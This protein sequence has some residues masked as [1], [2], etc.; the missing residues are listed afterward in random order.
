MLQLSLR[1]EAMK[2]EIMNQ[3]RNELLKRNEV[4]FRIDH[5]GS[6]T[7]TRQEVRLKLAD[8]L[9]MD[10]GKI[11]IQKFTTKK[12]SMTAT[13]QANVYDVV[14]EAKY[15]EPKHIILRNTFK[16]KD[17]KEGDQTNVQ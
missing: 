10:S 8:I 17:T 9:Q 7:P 4:I 5:E 11:Y 3:Q 13:G 15:A 12:G 1:V 2:I 6:G 16:R 14:E